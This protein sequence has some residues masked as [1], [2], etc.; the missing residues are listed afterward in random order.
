MWSSVGV[1]EVS[2]ILPDGHNYWQISRQRFLNVGGRARNECFLLSP[3][4]LPS[5]SASYTHR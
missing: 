4:I 3:L 2:G 1:W 5:P